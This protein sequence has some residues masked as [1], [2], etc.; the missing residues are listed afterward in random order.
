MKLKIIILF[1]SLLILF[2]NL[3]IIS[4]SHY[5]NNYN[6]YSPNNYYINY[7]PKLTSISSDYR[8]YDGWIYNSKSTSYKYYNDYY[9]YYR[10][11]N[12]YEKNYYIDAYY[13]YFSYEYTKEYEEKNTPYSYSKYERIDTRHL[14]R[15]ETYVILWSYK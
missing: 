13:P 3:N 14:S 12:Y 6:Y 9:P 4:A 1:A 11:A 5:Y 10:R 15:P 2:T 8:N 7:N